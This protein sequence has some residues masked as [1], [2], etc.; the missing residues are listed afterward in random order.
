MEKSKSSS[1]KGKSTGTQSQS[2]GNVQPGRCARLPS[3]T[4]PGSSHP[5]HACL[6][7]WSPVTQSLVDPCV[8][9]QRLPCWV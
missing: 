4:G 3:M 9:V 2:S 8:L 1:R 5:G 7:I 6:S